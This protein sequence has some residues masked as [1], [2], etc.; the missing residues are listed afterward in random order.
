VTVAEENDVSVEAGWYADPSGAAPYRWWDGQ[1]WS[2]QTSHEPSVPA[3]PSEPSVPG[4]PGASAPQQQPQYGQAQYGQAQYGQ[5]QYGQSQYGQS[6]YGQSQYGQ[7]QYGQAQYGQQPYQH[8]MPGSP[9]GYPPGQQP[10]PA[11][12]G[13]KLAFTTL[14]I[15]AVYFVLLFAA[16]VVILG[17]LPALLA[18]RS[19][20]RHEPLAPVAIVAA[21]VAVI[22]AV[23]TLVHGG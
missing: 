8:G 23:L 11:S 19:R 14:A 2:A 5:A 17:I 15:V 6:Q 4:G 9:V 21:A 20:E 3:A 16:G 13:N 22:A 12:P 18:Y 1:A 10:Q 7:P